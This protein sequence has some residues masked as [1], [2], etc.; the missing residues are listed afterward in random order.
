V[1]RTC[2]KGVIALIVGLWRAFIQL[3]LGR[4]AGRGRP[5]MAGATWDT[6]NRSAGGVSLIEIKGAG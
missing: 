4:M 5:S 6:V 2:I 3:L 1:F